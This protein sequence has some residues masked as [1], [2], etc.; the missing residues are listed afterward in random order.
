E[1]RRRSKVYQK[2]TV[3]EIVKEVLLAGGFADDAV[4]MRLTGTHA[5]KRYVTQF[6]ETDAAFIRRLCEEDGLYFRS[7]PG[8]HGET[9]VLEDTSAKA[10]AA[11]PEHLYVGQRE[12]SIQA[13]HLRAW[14][15]REVRRR[16]P[17][18]VT[19][20]AYDPEHP[21]VPLEGVAT[22]GKSTEQ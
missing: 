20:R 10:P 4:V 15:C 7:A 21:S 22:G 12:G 9:F 6:D 17:G 3:P 11:L 1:L 2:L 14:D 19:L 16:R 18:K 5:K 8:E 13:L